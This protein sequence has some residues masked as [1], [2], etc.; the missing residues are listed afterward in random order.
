MPQVDVTL[1][2]LLLEFLACL[3][4]AHNS[5]STPEQ[6]GLAPSCDIFP[7]VG[8]L[9]CRFDLLHNPRDLQ[10]AY[11][12]YLAQTELNIG[13]TP[14]VYKGRK[15]C[16]KLLSIYIP[17]RTFFAKTHQLMPNYPP[18]KKDSR[19]PRP[20]LSL[21]PIFPRCPRSANKCC[22]FLLS[23]LRSC[24]C[25]IWGRGSIFRGYI[26]KV[27]AALVSLSLGEKNRCGGKK[28]AFLKVE[29]EGENI[30]VTGEE[31][32]PYKS[33]SRPCDRPRGKKAAYVHY[34][35]REREREVIFSSSAC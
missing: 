31:K 6:H 28:G 22:L 9:F 30:G 15:G 8:L 14:T 2:L 24:F 11:T 34:A 10:S 27:Q 1:L 23:Y 3:H 33:F 4:R 12:L 13:K 25:L 16:H 20:L 19:F 35:R 5:K 18:F 29:K 26:G 17:I 32:K 21:D 7:I